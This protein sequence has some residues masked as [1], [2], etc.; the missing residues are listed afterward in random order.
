[1]IPLLSQ[2]PLLKEKI[3]YIP[4][5]EFPTPI[6]HLVELGVTIGTDHLYLK[7]DGVS[8]SPYGGN[9]I[10]KLEF[11]LADAIKKKSKEALTLM[12]E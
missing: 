6:E 1:M 9:K 7:N 2:Y 4:L 8:G 12:T 11:L 3:P 5:G 10:R